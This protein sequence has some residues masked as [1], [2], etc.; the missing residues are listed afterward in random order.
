MAFQLTLAFIVSYSVIICG[1]SQTYPT[2]VTVPSNAITGVSLRCSGV[3]PLNWSTNGTNFHV[4]NPPVGINFEIVGG[5]PGTQILT[6]QKESV[7]TFNGTSFQCT[8]GGES[9]SSVPTAF[10]IVYGKYFFC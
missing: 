1:F 6:I 3:Q 4:G 5:Q 7:L 10:I 8:H 9:F 2:N